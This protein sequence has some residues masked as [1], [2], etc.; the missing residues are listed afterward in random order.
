[1]PGTA[2]RWNG[3]ETG[4]TMRL[5]I[6]VGLIALLASGCSKEQ[7]DEA[8][9]NKSK[10]VQNLG[11]DKSELVAALKATL[12][13]AA[14][15][16]ALVT[17]EPFRVWPRALAGDLPFGWG[18]RAEDM[19]MIDSPVGGGL[20]QRMEL[21]TA[22]RFVIRMQPPPDRHLF[23]RCSVEPST[24]GDANQ[25]GLV[26]WEARFDNGQPPAKGSF[27][28]DPTS[29][30]WSAATSN[31]TTGNAGY[32]QIT[33]PMGPEPIWAIGFCDILPFEMPPP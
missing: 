29:N 23:F 14:K 7:P 4:V 10:K 6:V 3:Y 22:G 25:P 15:S 32:V 8:A 1:M 17:D 27:S 31:A 26:Q 13:G 2:S 28:R 18:V 33:S 24:L 12:G 20:A 19:Q 5:K 9:V 21:R 16:A 11:P 30:Y